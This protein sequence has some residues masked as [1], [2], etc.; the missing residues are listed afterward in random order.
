MS[1]SPRPAHQ[2]FVYGTF[3]WVGRKRESAAF[4]ALYG[5][6]GIESGSP[7]IAVEILREF[8]ATE[9]VGK[10]YTKPVRD[11]IVAPFHKIRDTPW[12]KVF[13]EEADK[14]VFEMQGSGPW[15]VLH[16]RAESDESGQYVAVAL[17][18]F[19]SGKVPGWVKTVRALVSGGTGKLSDL[20]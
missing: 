12:Y 20:A 9:F 18:Q 2:P 14:V 19:E 6:A 15:K 3:L 1:P 17:R 5:S 16:F 4:Q 10:L 13:E 7:D 11:W 8:G